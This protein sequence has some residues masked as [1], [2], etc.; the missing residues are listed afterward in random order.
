MSNLEI[1]TNVLNI[2]GEKAGIAIRTSTICLGAPEGRFRGLAARQTLRTEL[3][4]LLT[5][6]WVNICSPLL[7]FP[8]MLAC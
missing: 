7:L 1:H 8:A 2:A 3:Y 5:G 4:T 6:L